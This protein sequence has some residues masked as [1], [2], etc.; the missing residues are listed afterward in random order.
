MGKESI[1]EIPENSDNLY[2]YEYDEGTGKTRY[3]G[4][5]GDAP[6]L[7]ETEFLAAIEQRSGMPCPECGSGETRSVAND[8]IWCDRCKKH[9]VLEHFVVDETSKKFIL[10][11]AKKRMNKDLA[12]ISRN[13]HRAIPL[14]DIFKSLKKEG[15]VP[16]QEDMTPWAGLL[17]GRD[18]RASIELV[19]SDEFGIY[20]PVANAMLVLSWYKMEQ[21][22]NYEVNAYVS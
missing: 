4:P 15:V 3:R 1:V 17:L 5:V 11:G 22:G 16:V 8:I 6:E 7:G 10:T 9:I 13:Y 21:T 18:G 20:H 14:D 2:R 12:E 19:R